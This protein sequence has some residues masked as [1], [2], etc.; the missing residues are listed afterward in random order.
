MSL[1]NIRLMNGLMRTNRN[2][3]NFSPSSKLN[4]ALGS[5]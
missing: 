1:A 2:M 5:L 4:A 3:I